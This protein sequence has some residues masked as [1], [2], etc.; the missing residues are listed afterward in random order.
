VLAF[1]LVGVALV[2]QAL[3]DWHCGFGN[4]GPLQEGASVGIVLYAGAIVLTM[5]SG[6]A[7]TGAAD[8]AWRKQVWRMATV[9]LALV[10]LAVNREVWIEMLSAKPCGP[11]E[12]EDGVR[13][14]FGHA[15]IGVGYGVMPMLV[16]V[17]TGFG[18]WRGSA[19][20]SR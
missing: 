16:A 18:F 5:R 1:G 3:I 19:R 14:R 2:I 17:A 11:I 15:L 13:Y 9:G 10:A 7:P 4:T 12:Y 20:P 6:V 8:Q